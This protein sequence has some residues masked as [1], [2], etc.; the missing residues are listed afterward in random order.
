MKPQ[1]DTPTSP[2][3]APRSWTTRRDEKARRLAAVSGWLEDGVLP[4]ARMTDALELLIRPGDRV[5]LEGDNQKQADFLSRSL[6][7]ADPAKVNNVHLLISSISRPEHLTLFERGIAHRVDFAF[8]GAQSLRVAQLLEDDQLEVGAI[9][10]YVELYARMFV[11]LIPQ[12]ALLCAEK[13]DRHGNL[14][15]GPN[16]E[17]TPTIAE[18]A[19]FSQGIVIVQVNE[20]VDE[21]P[22]VDI[23]G[24]WVDVVVQADRPFAVEPLFTRDPRHIGDLQVLT[25]MMVIKGIYAPY[26]IAALNHGIGF[27]TAAI[28]LLLPTYGESLGLKG[29]IC[30]NWTLNPHPTLIPAIESGWVESVHCFGSEV[31][32]E[33]YI[34]AR[35][36]VFFTGSDG[37]LRSNRVLCQ[38]AGQY[39]VDLFIGSTLQIDADANSSTVTRGRLAGFGGAPNMGH[40][41]RGRRHA[42]EAWL[43]LLKDNGPV[44]RG[45]KLVVQLA[46]TWKKGGEP[47]FVDELDA[48][49]VGQ[50]SGMPVAPVMIY[51]DD[52]SHVVT[53]EGIA[54]LHRAEGIDERR[55]ALAAVA[56]V[57]PI[58]LRAQQQK[59]DELRR[60]GIVQFPEDLGILRGDAKRSLLAARSIDDLVTW[61]GGLYTPPARFRSW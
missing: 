47:T 26:G 43:K 57:T 56:G 61:S 11:D 7:K 32:M 42:S 2:D 25:A 55:A 21:L 12:V 5:A 37:S 18:A 9:H 46:E 3:L 23:P 33:A 19:A 35:P 45:H 52:V 4:A 6:A 59:T 8:A 53:E 24:S 36:D 20:I 49:A 58:G 1:A 30:R 17:D 54:H 51:G 48:I 41:P 27:D 10:T 15:T 60:R 34:A 14:Y 31:G 16:T 50:K 40:D 44:S 28:E 22:R 13:A 39:A 29:K 38:L